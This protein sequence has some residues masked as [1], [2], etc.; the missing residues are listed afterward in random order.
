MAKKSSQKSELTKKLIYGGALELFAKKGFEKATIREL[1]SELGIS[2]GNLYYHFKSKDDILLHYFRE[3]QRQTVLGVEAAL[4]P[5]QSV[6]EKLKV[7]MMV[8]WE[9]LKENEAITRGL[10]NATSNLS[11]PLSPFGKE[12]AE[13][14]ISALELF[15]E[16]LKAEH[17]EGEYLDAL[18]FLYWFYYLGIC[19]C[20][21]NDPSKNQ[22]KTQ[23]LFD[24]SFP[25]TRKL[26]ALT[27]IGV[28]R[29]LLI[30]VADLLR[31]ILI[32]WP[33]KES[34]RVNDSIK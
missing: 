9:L 4:S 3:L 26:T 21:A 31:A 33:D 12:L 1:A 24:L 6:S 22:A 27:R 17:K 20:W 13:C 8:N 7:V 25:L 18:A 11:H 2:L 28:G 10:I 23:K 5:K 34:P 19:L 16:A 32:R 29:K 14:Q 15:K 30:Q